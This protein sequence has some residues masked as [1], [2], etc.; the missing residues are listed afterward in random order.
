MIFG[1]DNAENKKAA[2]AL[3][4]F[5]GIHIGHIAVLQSAINSGLFPVAVT[6]FDTQKNKN[7]LIMS[8]EKKKDILLGMGFKQVVMMNYEAVKN[9]LPL[10]YLS[11][12]RMNFDPELICC[13]E[14]YRFGI[15][16]SAGV[17]ILED[18]CRNHG[19]K[20]NIIPKVCDNNGNVVASTSLRKMISEGRVEEANELMISRFSFTKNV[21]RGDG[22]GHELGFPTINQE[23]PG[24]LVVPKFGV[25]ASKVSVND[26]VFDAVTNIGIRPTR[27]SDNPICETHI[28]GFSDNIYDSEVT[29]KLCKFLREEMKF[30]T[31]EQLAE[32]I[33]NDI[34]TVQ[35]E[36][37]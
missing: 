15:N 22:I 17:D 16:A 9:W 32:A 33:C 7:K 18:Y 21:M 37:E 2:L 24:E 10:P 20:A 28:I 35:K 36:N 27:P 19:I 30:E 13:G 8:P 6:F 26:Q 14:N 12:L 3:G 34:K 1:I 23:L 29:V 5:D 25:Y 11:S 31:K 4:M